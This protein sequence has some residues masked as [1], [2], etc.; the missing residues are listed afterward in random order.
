[1][2][3]TPKATKTRAVIRLLGLVLV[4]VGIY[5]VIG[6]LVPTFQGE[7]SYFL[8][9]F[10]LLILAFCAFCVYV[11][12]CL[13]LRISPT[14]IRQLCA[15]VATLLWCLALGIAGPAHGLFPALKEG[16]FSSVIGAIVV[17]PAIIIYYQGS[18]RLIAL[19]SLEDSSDSSQRR[20]GVPTT[21]IFLFSL[22]LFFAVNSLM[23]DFGLY[24]E[25]PGGLW[26][27]VVLFGP[28]LLAIIVYKLGV[29]LFCQ[30]AHRR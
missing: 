21:P 17:V 8:L 16:A 13:W 6:T 23:M 29:F 15:I 30:R 20:T 12:V 19:A 5:G 1:M 27:L 7:F 9:G 18:R 3:L 14:S 28:L 10:C 24:E 2:C 11:A 22:L 4:A 25:V 26:R